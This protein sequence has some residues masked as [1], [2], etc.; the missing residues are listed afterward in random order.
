MLCSFGLTLNLFSLLETKRRSTTSNR[1][2]G[3]INSVSN[4]QME[5]YWLS[6]RNVLSRGTRPS[7]L[8]VSCLQMV[9]CHNFT[10]FY[11][12]SLKMLK[13]SRDQGV[14]S[15]GRAEST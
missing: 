13:S 11:A 5:G 4:L 6:A 1:Q 7:C 15:S 2:R 9:D 14:L 12:V 3:T 8:S 10:H